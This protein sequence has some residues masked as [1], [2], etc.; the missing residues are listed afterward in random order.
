LT[1][2]AT[3][4]SSNLLTGSPVGTDMFYYDPSNNI[5]A[6]RVTSST[7]ANSYVKFQ[8]TPL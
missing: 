7:G 4:F 8:I 3:S 5:I 2:L 1:G 6:L